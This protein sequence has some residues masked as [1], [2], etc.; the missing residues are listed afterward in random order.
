MDV[1]KKSSMDRG[2]HQYIRMEFCSGGD[3]EDVVRRA[4][5]LAVPDVRALLFQM[6][7]AL[8][9]CREKLALR[10]FDVKLL[11]FFVTHG[12]ALLPPAQ[13]HRAR[14]D[15]AAQVPPI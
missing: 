1:P 11:N 9:A 4:G 3:L 6:C 13:Q 8:Y 5:Q 14:Q 10:H 2:S 7:Y 15:S 12:A